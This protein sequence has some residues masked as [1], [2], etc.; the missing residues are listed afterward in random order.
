MYEILDFYTFCWKNRKK[1]WILNFFEFFTDVF[2]FLFCDNS[3][4]NTIFVSFTIIY[5]D[6]SYRFLLFFMYCDFYR[7]KKIEDVSRFFAIL[8]IMDFFAR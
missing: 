8:F 2:L 7:K 6:F 4:L 1:Y 5:N 3:T